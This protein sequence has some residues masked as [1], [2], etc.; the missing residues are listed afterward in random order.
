MRNADL[1][2]VVGKARAAW[3][4]KGLE[5]YDEGLWPCA[6]KARNAWERQGLEF[7]GEGL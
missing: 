2:P 4:R 7:R 6:D 1:W 3:A 5:L